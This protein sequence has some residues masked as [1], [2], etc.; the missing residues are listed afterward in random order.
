VAGL[1][2]VHGRQRALVDPVGAALRSWTVDGVE[3]ASFREPGERGHAFD[4]ATLVPWVNRVPDGTYVHGG[5]PQQLPISDPERN[6]AIHGLAWGERWEVIAAGE[7]RARL[8]HRIAPQPG[9]P[10][11]VEAEVGYRLDSEGLSVELTAVNTGEE[12]APFGCGSHPYLATP[13]GVDAA[14]LEVAAQAF[15]PTDERLVPSGPPRPVDGTPLDL[16]SR[17]GLRDLRLDTCFTDLVRDD[18]GRARVRLWPTPAD[19]PITLWLDEAFPFVHLYTDDGHPDPA[20]GRERLAVEP[21]TCAPDAFNSGLGLLTLAP[22]VR[23]R[24]RWGTT[25]GDDA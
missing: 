1:T 11:A 15:V 6:S 18:D 8:R 24:A 16:R 4:G 3:R 17:R 19:G 12:A 21:V 22:G 14:A 9:Y 2:L 5:R 25:Q 7:D 20:R 23:F 13:A 10:F